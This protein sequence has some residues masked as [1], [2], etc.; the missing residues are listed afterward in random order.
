MNSALSM[1]TGVRSTRVKPLKTLHVPSNHSTPK[2][3]SLANLVEDE[4]DYHRVN[5]LAHRG[6]HIGT[7]S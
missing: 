5:Y 4:S 6:N 1:G 3:S 2:P 7:G